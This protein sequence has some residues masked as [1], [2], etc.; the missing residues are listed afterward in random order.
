MTLTGEGLGGAGCPNC[1]LFGKDKHKIVLANQIQTIFSLAL[2]VRRILC[3]AQLFVEM[4][5]VL[6]HVL[7]IFTDHVKIRMETPQAPQ[8]AIEKQG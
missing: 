2:Y 7:H 6:T 4:S 8:I 5:N 1:F 3:L